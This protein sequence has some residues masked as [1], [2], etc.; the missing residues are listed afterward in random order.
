MEKHRTLTMVKHFIQHHGMSDE[1][2]M[3]LTS[4]DQKV[5]IKA[6]QQLSDESIS[7]INNQ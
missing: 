6:R 3:K 4:V 2:I 5:L 7:K 1:V